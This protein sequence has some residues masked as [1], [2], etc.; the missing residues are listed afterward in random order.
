VA[1]A[2]A[3]TPAGTRHP[4]FGTEMSA[5]S[6]ATGRLMET[7][8]HGEDIAAALGVRRPPTARLRHVAF[9]GYRTL[10]HSFRM[11]G[12][13]APDTEVYLELT[14][15]DGSTWAYGSPDAPDRVGGPALDFCLLV[16]QRTHRRDTA[17]EATGVTAHEWL[18]VAQA[19][20][21]PPGTGRPASD[22]GA[23]AADADSTRAG[24]S[25]TA[26]IVDGV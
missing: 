22:N 6:S 9:L 3:G 8:A 16:T 13:S 7:W 12:R 11:H 1:Q 17:L 5:R 10:A 19:F 14:A 18:D 24:H 25:I 26:S 21:G 23:A 15:P 4:W 2:L 20:A